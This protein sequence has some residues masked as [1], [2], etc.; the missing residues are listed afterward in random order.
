MKTSQAIAESPA[1]LDKAKNK[2]KA[3]VSAIFFGFAAWAYTYAADA[4]KFWIATVA[5]LGLG[6]V[7]IFTVIE[8]FGS[9]VDW[10]TA[11]SQLESTENEPLQTIKDSWPALVLVILGFSGLW[12]WPVADAIRRPKAWY[13]NY[14]RRSETL[15]ENQALRRL[16]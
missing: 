6:I 11:I 3:V 16:L 15:K 12:I 5:S 1:D 8:I 2:T 14:G 7:M 13:E 9:F 10:L 4:K